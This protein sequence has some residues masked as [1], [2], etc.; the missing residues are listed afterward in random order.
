MRLITHLLSAV[1]FGASSVQTQSRPASDW[2][3]FKVPIYGTRLE[4]PAS[5]F[6]VGQAEM[7]VGH[8]FESDDGRAVPDYIRTRE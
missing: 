3:I 2:Q 5:I 8:R 4:Y 1:A 6:A 7:G